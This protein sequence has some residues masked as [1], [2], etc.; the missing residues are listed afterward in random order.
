MVF[1]DQKHK[2]GAQQPPTIGFIKLSR[3]ESPIVEKTNPIGSMS[4]VWYIYLHLVDFHGQC[5]YIYQT[6]ILLVDFYVF[7]CRIHL[8]GKDTS[9]VPK[10]I[11]DGNVRGQ[12][13]RT[14]SQR[15]GS[16]RVE[17]R[18]VSWVRWVVRVISPTRRK[19]LPLLGGSSHDL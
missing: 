6:W 11:R 13:E 2:A 15:K 19:N 16:R 10:G 12:E 8:V 5:R 3:L 1:L 17:G 4:H 9:F 14:R 18:A 7:S